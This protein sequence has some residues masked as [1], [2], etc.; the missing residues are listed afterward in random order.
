VLDIALNLGDHLVSPLRGL[1]SSSSLTGWAASLA[2]AEY[3]N[4]GYVLI[5]GTAGDAAFMSV[6]EGVLGGQLPLRPRSLVACRA[7]VVLWQSP[8]EWWLV[9]ARGDLARLAGELT[10]ALEGCFSQ[11]VDNSGG[12]TAVHISG[13]DCNLLL[14][15]LTPYDIDGLATHDCVS[16]AIGKATMTV[17]RASESSL[18]LVFRRSFASYIWQL[19]DRAALP[20]GMKVIS[21]VEAQDGLLAALLSAKDQ[22]SAANRA[23]RSGT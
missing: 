23:D 17:I 7:G 15:H 8:D 2:A 21:P 14:R 22:K 19:I 11:I 13:M 9:C 10:R 12:F 1:A 3:P 16:L 18:T 20:Y 6:V 5:R 4:L